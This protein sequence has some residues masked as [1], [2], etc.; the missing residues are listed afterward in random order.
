MTSKMYLFFVVLFTQFL[1]IQAMPIKAP[2][3]PDTFMI[4]LDDTTCGV[5]EKVCFEFKPPTV[6]IYA[7]IFSFSGQ[8]I[9]SFHDTGTFDIETSDKYPYYIYST[10]T[11]Y[12]I[13]TVFTFNVTES[14]L[15]PRRFSIRR[16]GAGVPTS[17]FIFYVCEPYKLTVR[18]TLDNAILKDTLLYVPTKTTFR[19]PKFNIPIGT[20][21]A[22][23]NLVSG[24]CSLDSTYSVTP[25]LTMTSD[26]VIEMILQKQGIPVVDTGLHHL[27]IAEHGFSG[28]PYDGILFR[29]KAPQ[30]GNYGY[31]IDCKG[32]MYW[33]TTDSALLSAG[34]R[35]Q[36]CTENKHMVLP[37]KIE[38]GL[39]MHFR[40]WGE[41]LAKKGAINIELQEARLKLHI[42]SIPKVISPVSDTLPRMRIGYI[43]SLFVP[44][45]Q[46]QLSVEIPDQRYR[47][48]S[49]EVLKGNA[50]ITKGQQISLKSDASIRPVVS[51]R[52][53]VEVDSTW[54]ILDMLQNKWDW[55][56]Q[57]SCALSF[58]PA[59]SGSYK[60]TAIR[61]DT[62]SIS[63]YKE[64][65]LNDLYLSGYSLSRE[66]TSGKSPLSLSFW[67][68]KDSTY[69][70]RIMQ[71]S[72]NLPVC[73]RF[74]VIVKKMIDSLPPVPEI[75][76]GITINKSIQKQSA[77]QS[78]IRIDKRY[79]IANNGKVTIYELSGKKVAV[80]QGKHLMIDRSTFHC[81]MY[82][83]EFIPYGTTSRSSYKF[84]E[85]K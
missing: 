64:T 79:I 67:G 11:P 76:P 16:G 6:G 60:L 10:K 4:E 62:T 21:L 78:D 8:S 80:S 53:I 22:R 46:K 58:R 28:D 59:S 25:S 31:R 47:L 44:G 69:Y 18:I 27:T 1:A 3:V 26:A 14:S 83:A 66:L 75:C 19:L 24:Q 12:E 13:N 43:D 48:D 2:V 52:S 41:D 35:S 32:D 39:F 84:I 63:I 74:A 73:N 37:V 5:I 33:S 20:K 81:G 38:D 57:I 23:W 9:Y 54:R 65:R 61:M 68:V 42:D 30:P 34:S 56:S 15:L 85:G 82:I 71:K 72:D 29:F 50:D 36:Y 17:S 40:G 55:N 77:F 7:G 51:I 45:W 70:I 49:F